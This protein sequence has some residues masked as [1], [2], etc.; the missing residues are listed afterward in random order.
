MDQ[1]K[2]YNPIGQYDIY[3]PHLQLPIELC[4]KKIRTKIINTSN[5][6]ANSAPIETSGDS[7]NIFDHSMGKRRKTNEK[8]GL[9]YY[10][11]HKPHE[12]AYENGGGGT[13]SLFISQNSI[14]NNN[15]GNVSLNIDGMNNDSL[16]NK[17]RTR[18]LRMLICVTMNN[19]NRE[20]LEITLNGIH[21]NLKSF[22]DVNCC[23]EDIAVVVIIDGLNKMHDSVHSLF[24]KH[25]KQMNIPKNKRLSF[26][27]QIFKNPENDKFRKFAAFPRDSLYC[28]QLTLKPD[29][30]NDFNFL[31]TFLCVKMQS[32]G[33]LASHLWFFRGFCEMFNPFYCV[34]TKAGVR[35][36]PQSIFE[37]FRTFEG[38]PQVGGLCGYTTFTPEPIYDKF[39]VLADKETL[40][41]IDEMSS[42]FSEVFDIQRAQC[43]DNIFLQI[44]EKPFESFFGFMSVLDSN[45]A[46]FRW[47]ALRKRRDCKNILDDVYLKTVL[48]NDY[49]KSKAFSFNKATLYLAEDRMMCLEIFN[50]KNFILKYIPKVISSVDPIKN[51]PNYLNEQRKIINREWFSMRHIM[52][53]CWRDIILGEH[54]VFRK[55]F[56]FVF[57]CFKLVEMLTTYLSCGVFFA[58]I[59]YFCDEIVG[60]F[61]V[62]K[63]VSIGDLSGAFLLILS[64]LF[65]GFLFYSSSYRVKERVDK[66]TFY[67]TC[68]MLFNLIF[69]AYLLYLIVATLIMRTKIIN[70]SLGVAY[71]DQI[72]SIPE[73]RQLVLINYEPKY[74]NIRS[75]M[76]VKPVYKEK[77]IENVI[78]I[79]YP[80]YLL[81]LLIINYGI[82]LFILFITS[83]KAILYDAFISLKDYLFYWPIFKI[84]NI[85]YAFSNIDELTFDNLEGGIKMET[86]SNVSTQANLFKL[87]Y[88]YKWSILD[89]FVS[90][91]L[92]ILFR[93]YIFK[94]WFLIGITAYF[95]LGTLLK[96][97]IAIIY[98]LKYYIIDRTLYYLRI[99]DKKK[100][101]IA[102]TYLVK[103]YLASHINREIQ[104]NSMI[105]NI[106]N[107][108][109]HQ[110]K[111][112]IISSNQVKIKNCLKINFC[113]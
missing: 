81:Y 104:S 88:I 94:K 53:T 111:N 55:M 18:N 103:N 12:K 108:F 92:I 80:D 37:I 79:F 17:L 112:P 69:F 109:N 22:T 5:E 10:L 31:N 50:R 73:L 106:S 11:T 102:N 62:Y 82:Q 44:L 2:V 43:F 52:K 48:D 42:L 3:Q 84:M 87:N 41:K 36:G 58:F 49:V 24:L 1:S 9:F 29:G 34:L 107:Q 95:T 59:Y 70:N 60:Q 19:E 54:G 33:T 25:D 71:V 45:L 32:T 76:S 23:D 68:I 20:D 7:L 67:G 30:N 66:F 83:T 113:K 74:P 98:L 51:L 6:P 110:N 64:L 78:S 77:I 75:C 14:N 21:E 35:A 91:S 8:D 27:E 100:E 26:R 63:T 15:I 105:Y 97:C 57:L 4:L 65:G 85:V 38:D 56:F 72:N 28:Y 89:M 46:G 86:C 40:S 90:Y 101:Y 13:R 99:L 61:R 39:G 16:N 47:D 96:T 93:S